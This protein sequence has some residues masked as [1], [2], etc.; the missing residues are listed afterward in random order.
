MRQDAAHSDRMQDIGFATFT[1][2]AIMGNI[3]IITG[4]KH[5][6]DFTGT[7]ISVDDDIKLLLGLTDLWAWHKTPLKLNSLLKMREYF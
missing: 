2:N 4:G 5:T 3:R 7:Q 6:L 1:G